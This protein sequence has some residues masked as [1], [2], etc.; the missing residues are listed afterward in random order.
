LNT[1][2][3]TKTTFHH[4]LFDLQTFVFVLGFGFGKRAFSFPHFSAHHEVPRAE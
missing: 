1:K 2:K 4:L 3:P